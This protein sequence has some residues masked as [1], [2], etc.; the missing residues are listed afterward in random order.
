MVLLGTIFSDPGRLQCI[1]EPVRSSICRL[2]KVSSH[3]TPALWHVDERASTSWLVGAS[4]LATQP[5]SSL[6]DAARSMSRHRQAGVNLWTS[7]SRLLDAAS[8]M[9]CSRPLYPPAFCWGQCASRR[10]QLCRVDAANVRNNFKCSGSSQQ[11]QT[12]PKWIS[13][14]QFQNPL[15]TKSTD[16][17]N[18][19]WASETPSSNTEGNVGSGQF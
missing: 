17:W 11:S 7:T 14:P 19:S 12:L 2:I 3:S 16:T 5:A 10:P 1:H 8:S 13:W 6:V 9:P 18:A 4:H 15:A